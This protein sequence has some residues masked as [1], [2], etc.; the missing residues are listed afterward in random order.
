MKRDSL[1]LVLVFALILGLGMFSF[2]LSSD[3]HSI[4][5]MSIYSTTYGEPLDVL[6]LIGDKIENI[7]DD[8][9]IDFENESVFNGE[10]IDIF[11]LELE[12]DERSIEEFETEEILDLRSSIIGNAFLYPAF[13]FTLNISAYETQIENESYQNFSYFMN[14]SFNITN[15]TV[16][17]INLTNE[18]NN[19]TYLINQ[20]I[21]NTYTNYLFQEIN[22]TV[23]DLIQNNSLSQIFNSSFLEDINYINLSSSSS[24]TSNLIS[25]NISDSKLLDYIY[26]TSNT[27]IDLNELFNKT[28]QNYTF[29]VTEFNTDDR[30]FIIRNDLKVGFNKIEFEEYNGSGIS[31]TDSTLELNP[32]FN[33]TAEF[34]ID[35]ELHQITSKHLEK[36]ENSIS[37]FNLTGKA[38]SELSTIYSN[39]DIINATAEFNFIE[40]QPFTLNVSR[41]N[42]DTF[43]LSAI[44]NDLF[45]DFDNLTIDLSKIDFDVDVDSLGDK[46]LTLAITN[47]NNTSYYDYS[48]NV[49]SSC[50]ENWICNAT[51]RCSIDGVRNNVCVDQNNCG[52]EFTKPAEKVDCVYSCTENFQC[53]SFGGCNELGIKRRACTDVN[54]CYNHNPN[55]TTIITKTKPADFATCYEGCEEKWVCDS[56]SDCQNGKQTRICSDVNSCPSEILKP[57]ETKNCDEAVN[58]SYLQYYDKFV[59]SSKYID[60]TRNGIP[61]V[62]QE[63]QTATTQ[64]TTTVNEEVIPSPIAEIESNEP[65]NSESQVVQEESKSTITETKTESTKEEDKVTGFSIAEEP[66]LESNYFAVLGVLSIFIISLISY[67]QRQY[68][69]EFSKSENKKTYFSKYMK[70]KKFDF[71]NVI[72]K[73]RSRIKKENKITQGEEVSYEQN[74]LNSFDHYNEITMPATN[75]TQQ[76]N[77]ND[78]S[79]YIQYCRS[80]G[81]DDAQIYSALKS[82]G[83]SD[84]QISKHF[85]GNTT[86]N[87]N[88]FNQIR[89]NLISSNEGIYFKRNF[90]FTKQM[91]MK[92]VSEDSI[93]YS[94]QKRGL[95]EQDALET[96]DKAKEHLGFFK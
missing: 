56:W 62:E 9:K 10:L 70:Q 12:K 43:V 63:Q 36:V 87:M 91:I 96:I 17:K 15:Q 2:M 86:Q 3:F 44:K 45:F 16:E 57:I 26:N 29:K 66:E 39:Y 83:H 19:E 13:N 5:G 50:I 84:Y 74:H 22:K 60:L 65:T 88:R 79:S 41:E 81:F 72:S 54:H 49:H 6:L 59:K 64:R 93:I 40:Q 18:S 67:N 20:T 69:L 35:N 75:I 42:V 8:I 38:E 71:D 85:E 28:Y 94:L 89:Q 32:I 25:I 31:I 4:T 58:E 61:K 1:N 90:E 68:I 46:N 52:T 11:D 82:V 76:A 47:G 23:Y 55:V 80:S 33:Q 53:D 30:N 14:I 51:D 21:N 92:N 78:I 73:V 24:N 77:Y 34:Y 27:S 37:I 48:V 95:N 7:N